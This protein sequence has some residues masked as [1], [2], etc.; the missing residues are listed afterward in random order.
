MHRT[1]ARPRAPK[2]LGS[3]ERMWFTDEAV[4]W[5][6]S[7]DRFDPN[8]P[9]QLWRAPRT[10]ELAP[11][12]IATGEHRGWVGG[13]ESVVLRAGLPSEGAGASDL[14]QETLPDLTP[15]QIVGTYYDAL[16]L[17][18]DGQSLFVAQGPG[19]TRLMRVML[20]G[21]SE[22]VPVAPENQQ[23][24]K[25]FLEGEWLY[26]GAILESGLASIQ[27]RPRDLSAEPEEL[28]R[29]EFVPTMFAVAADSVVYFAGE[30]F[31]VKPLP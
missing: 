22:P 3:A 26:W 10:G 14:V 28:V 23:V 25:L 20:D 13:S 6:S 17:A 2:L 16:T 4:W 19:G 11:E 1:A 15:S 12:Q 21:S 9:R 8:S 18:V 29:G 24:R 7:E 5:S 31:F 27:R 30:R